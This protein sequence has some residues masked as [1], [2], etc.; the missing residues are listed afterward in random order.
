MSV[1]R[2]T[3]DFY[4]Q[5]R[6]DIPPNVADVLDAAAPTGTRRRL[7]DVGTG[8][9]LVVEAPLGRFDDI[10]AFD[11]DADLLAAAET[12]LCT[13]LPDDTHLQLQEITAEKFVPLAGWHADL[14]TICR[15]FHWLDQA[16]VLAHL[17]TQVSPN[18]RR[19][20]R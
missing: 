18:G 19:N 16:T 10:I 4:R 3:A 6:P 9:G 12:A 11:N 20:L 13:H 7:L 15:A 8:T 1:F 2:G 5:Y 14:V 17:G